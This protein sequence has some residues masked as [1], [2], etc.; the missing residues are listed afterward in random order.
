MHNK[1]IVFKIRRE[2]LTCWHVE[3]EFW[4]Q[5]HGYETDH[6]KNITFNLRYLIENRNRTVLFDWVEFISVFFQQLLVES[7]SSLEWQILSISGE[8]LKAEGK[9]NDFNKPL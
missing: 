3:N 4:G 9:Q 6:L 2:Q 8:K 7:I 5:K 1:C